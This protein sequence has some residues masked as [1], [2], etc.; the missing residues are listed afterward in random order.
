MSDK[1]DMNNG[2]LLRSAPVL[3]YFLKAGGG[4]KRV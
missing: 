2:G 3:L 4:V 1:E